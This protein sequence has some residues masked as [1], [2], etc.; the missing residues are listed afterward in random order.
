MPVIAQ[1][2]SLDNYTGTWTD[3]NTWVSGVSPGTT[4][5]N[6]DIFIYG[7]VRRYG[8][9]SFNQGD[10]TVNDTLVIYGNLTLG[11]NS[12]LFLS[13]GSILI[14]YGDYTSGNMVQVANGG[15]M[16][17]TGSWIMNGSNN[18]GGFDNDG[19][20]YILDPNPD[21]K[22]GTGYEDFNCSAPVDSCQQYGLE[23]LIG[24]GIGEFFSAGNYA[25]SA[26]QDFLCPGGTVLLYTADS[27]TNY[28]WYL[29][30]VAITGATSSSYTASATGSYHVV[31]SL[32]G[33]TFN[34]DPFTLSPD[35]T[36][37]EIVGC[38]GNISATANDEYCGNTISWTAPQAID[39]CTVT[40]ASTHA[41][42]DF[43][44]V[45]TTTV[46]YTAV[47]NS[48]NS[49]QCSFDVIVNPASP[50][51]IT[52]DPDVCTPV[53]AAYSTPLL[54]GKTYLWS[55]TEGS[56]PGTAASADV[57]ISWTGAVA[58][59]VSVS[60][61]SGSGCSINNSLNVTKSLTPVT[62]D[63][64]PDTNLIRR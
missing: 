12:S 33:T 50:P 26:G 15:I 36:P 54:A 55:V 2:S 43:F 59:T 25:I 5:I 8:N 41:P 7:Y 11:N 44:P 60:V 18:Q 4:G 27:G 1:Q 21:L 39:S 47:D 35:T 22:T 6:A 46:V 10:L 38:P 32:E 53:I 29:N 24:S 42:G 40:L 23:D 57:S 61:T 64:L 9:L 45:G 13:A 20:L 14:V 31:F 62:D 28:Q 3:N 49:S 37:P 34:L 52:G 58:G 19:Q 56:I 17:V 48:G 63:I 16:V 30:G 51:V